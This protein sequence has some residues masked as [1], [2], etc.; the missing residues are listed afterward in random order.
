MG[1]HPPGAVRWPEVDIALHGRHFRFDPPAA[2]FASRGNCESVFPGVY[3]APDHPSVEMISTNKARQFNLM[4]VVKMGLAGLTTISC[5]AGVTYLGQLAGDASPAHTSPM[6]PLV[7]FTFVAGF[8]YGE[9]RAPAG[10]YYAGRRRQEVAPWQVW[11]AGLTIPVVL[12]WLVYRLFFEG[13][14]DSG[15]VS[16]LSVLLNSILLMTTWWWAVSSS[17]ELRGLDVHPE[18]LPDSRGFRH[19]HPAASCYRQ[20]C[21]RRLRD[22]WIAGAIVLAGVI[23]TLGFLSRENHLPVLEVGLYLVA[24]FGLLALSNLVRSGAT[25]RIEQIR[26]PDML[27]RRWMSSALA[28]VAFG[29]ATSNRLCWHIFRDVRIVGRDVE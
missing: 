18:E 15:G 7:L 14:V 28:F 2:G 5:L 20:T 10:F 22:R 26:L 1:L 6:L 17:T 29:A 11:L 16:G 12:H 19:E 23:A 3:D 21:F 27:A 4:P 8:C 24:G 13:S 9:R 25:W